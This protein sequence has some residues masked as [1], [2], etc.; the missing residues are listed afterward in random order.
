MLSKSNISKRGRKGLESKVELVSN[1][2]VISPTTDLI[3][4]IKEIIRLDL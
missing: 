2:S 1:M 4:V 3:H